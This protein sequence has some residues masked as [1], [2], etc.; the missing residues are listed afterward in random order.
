[1][2]Q[3]KLLRLKQQAR[4][5]DELVHFHALMISLDQCIPSGVSDNNVSEVQLTNRI[6]FVVSPSLTSPGLSCRTMFVFKV[7]D[8]GRGVFSRIDP[9]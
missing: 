5:L 3:G 4:K 9:K 8:S 2:Y 1:M 7:S 6:S